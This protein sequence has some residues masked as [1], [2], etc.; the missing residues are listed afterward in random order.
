MK[1][2]VTVAAMMSVCALVAACSLVERAMPGATMSDADLLGVW[3]T[4]NHSEIDAG[5]LARDR[6]SSEEVLAYASRMVHDHQMHMQDADRLAHRIRMEPRKPALASTFENAHQKAM[7]ELRDNAGLNFDKSYI[8]YQI[9]L[10]QQAINLVKDA[11][12]WVNDPQVKRFLGEAVPDL[13]SHL[14][15]A[16]S[17]QRRILNR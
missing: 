10:H 1:L 6:A 9:T 3:N 14:E 2:L 13:Q 15:A 17:V 12:E 7:E 16:H 5:Q 4:I 8:G 11:V